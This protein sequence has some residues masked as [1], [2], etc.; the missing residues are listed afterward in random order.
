MILIPILAWFLV[1]DLLI[2]D[3]IN[4]KLLWQEKQNFL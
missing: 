1:C 3:S 4:T 2:L